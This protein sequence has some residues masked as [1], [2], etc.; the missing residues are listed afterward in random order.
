MFTKKINLETK[1]IGKHWLVNAKNLN[2]SLTLQRIFYLILP[3][4]GLGV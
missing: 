3:F 4:E 1:N 2:F